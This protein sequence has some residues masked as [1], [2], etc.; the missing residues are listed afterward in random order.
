MASKPLVNK[1][2]ILMSNK[3]YD[4]IVGIIRESYPNSCILYIDEISV[5]SVNQMEFEMVYQN[6]YEKRGE[7]PEIKQLYHG[8]DERSANNIIIKG[9]D[10]DYN[11][12]SAFGKGSY[13]A[14][15]ATMSSKYSKPRK[16]GICFMLVCD[17]LVGKCVQYRL[18]KDDDY[19][20]FIDSNIKPTIYV[21]PYKNGAIPRYLVAYHRNAEM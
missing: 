18:S 9:F 13:F 10:P 8:T 12:V 15:S 5:P 20:N 3:K 11:T 21:S 16:D 4:E 6:I 14:T 1:K 17:V 19:D 7:Y 2:P